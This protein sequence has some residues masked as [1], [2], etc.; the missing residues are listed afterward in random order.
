M[1]LEFEALALEEFARYELYWNTVFALQDSIG[2]KVSERTMLGWI[3]KGLIIVQDGVPED[4][5]L[6]TAAWL[7]KYDYSALPVVFVN[8]MVA[9]GYGDPAQTPIVRQTSATTLSPLTT[10]L[11]LHPTVSC[12]RRP[13]CLLGYHP[14]LRD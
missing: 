3:Q 5:T 11:A 4:F 2:Y 13:V 8:A 6:T 7:A 9:Y 10:L 12:P 14:R 1:T